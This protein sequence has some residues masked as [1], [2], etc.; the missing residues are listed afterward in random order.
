MTNQELTLDPPDWDEFRALAHR[1]VDD[2]I[3][4]LSSLH[5]QPAW[6]Q[7]PDDVRGSFAGP[8]PRE[9]AGAEAAYRDFAE[10]VRPY[11]NGNLHPR[12]WGWV[13]GN[14]TPLGMMAEMLAAALN[15]HLAGFDQAPALVEKQVIAWLAEMMGFPA[16]A[17]GLLVTGGTMA[18]VLGVAVARHAKAGFD[19]RAEGLQGGRPRML[20]YGSGETH[21]WVK[22][23]AELLGL[24][25]ASFRPIRVDGDDRVDVEAMRAA[26]RADRAAGHHPFCAIGTAGTVNTGATDDLRALAALCREEGLWFHVDGAFGALARLSDELAPLVAGMEEA[27]SLGFDLHKWMYLPFECACVLVRD[28]EQ[29][30]AAFSITASYLAETTRGVIAGGIPFADLGVDLTRGF[31]AL[32]VWMSL[33]AHGVD[34][35]ARLIEQNVAQAR[36]LAGL[37]EADPSLELLA[38][39]ALNVVSFRYAAAGVPEERLDAINQEI[40]LRVQEAGIAV[41]SGTLVR[42][43]YAIRVANVNH[44]SRRED[45]ELLARSVARIGRE[46][47]NS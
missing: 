30:R 2:T 29:H 22:R 25:H 6:R 13:Q 38:P 14:G 40:L 20:L 27:D 28:A 9:G 21:G 16:G 24:G 37:V 10:R 35:I 15:P 41:P 43:R 17:S 46:V 47:E 18:N 42:G 34:A 4:H 3:A 36:H 39:V 7:M 33:K 44:R 12:F 1:M 5:E 19:V 23:C 32:K 8:L 45:F 31:K 26:I 11:P